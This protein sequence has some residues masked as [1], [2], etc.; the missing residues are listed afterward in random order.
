MKVGSG[1]RGWRDVEES[2]VEGVQDPRAGPVTQV[3]SHGAHRIP[4]Q[5]GGDDRRPR[6]GG[7]S[8]P[9][10]RSL[11]GARD[12]LLECS[13]S[14]DCD[15]ARG[16]AYSTL[17]GPRTA[18]RGMSEGLA[19][20]EAACVKRGRRWLASMSHGS[21]MATHRT[22]THR[23]W[24]PGTPCFNGRTIPTTVHPPSAPPTAAQ[25]KTRSSLLPSLLLLRFSSLPPTDPGL[26]WTRHHQIFRHSIAPPVS[27]LRIDR[28]LL[29]TLR[30]R[31][32]LAAVAGRTS[33]PRT[34]ALRRTHPDPALSKPTHT[35][36][37]SHCSLPP[38]SPWL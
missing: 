31:S 6:L 3:T 11:P 25:L 23:P 1:G 28:S 29:G 32:P 7:T 17:G 4:S 26:H 24:D 20:E 13:V 9:P 18:V 36:D 2:Q 5:A 34:V 12:P 33:Q 30:R 16:G 21:G 35:P 19:R 14:P 22:H 37:I 27:L 38:A 8:P 10:R 15:C